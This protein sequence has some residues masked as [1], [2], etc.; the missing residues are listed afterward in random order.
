MLDTILKLVKKMKKSNTYYIYIINKL[1]DLLPLFSI[2]I[3][4]LM[5]LFLIFT[6]KIQY[7]PIAL[8]LLLSSIVYINL[9]NFKV[10][11]NSS[12]LENTKIS[13][14][15]FIT[16][17]AILYIISII[18]L[19]VLE[20]R[21]FLFFFT[22]SVAGAIIFI[23][24]LIS[25]LNLFRTT[26]IY[27][28]II[29]FALLI[30]WSLPYL[31]SYPLGID[32][33][34]FN[35]I[36]QNVI[37]SGYLNDLLI[38]TM[39]YHQPL[40]IVISSIYS[41]ILNV[42]SQFGYLFSVSLVEVLSLVFVALICNLFLQKKI[43]IISY[44]F[45]VSFS[46][47]IMWGW[48]TIAMT[49]GGS[50]FIIFIYT[51]LRSLSSDKFILILILIY[52]SLILTHALSSI[53]ALT[54]GTILLL[55]IFIFVKYLV[56]DENPCISPKK[57]ISISI[58]LGIISLFFWIYYSGMFTFYT[59][60]IFGKQVSSVLSRDT[61]DMGKIILRNPIYDGINKFGNIIAFFLTIMGFFKAINYTNSKLKGRFKGI[62]LAFIF[63]SICIISIT[64]LFPLLNISII[65]PTRWLYFSQIL[66]S[67]FAASG[68]MFILLR[69]NGIR[70]VILFAFIIFFSFT[71]FN[72]INSDASFD[73]PI[74]ED[75]TYFYGIKKYDGLS[76]Q[77]IASMTIDNLYAERYYS[78]TFTKQYPYKISDL[79][80]YNHSDIPE[81]S[82]V[83][84]RNN[85][86][87]YYKNNEEKYICNVGSNEHNFNKIYSTKYVMG[88][89][90]PQ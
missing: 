66:M 59:N 5:I 62:G 86:I 79:S 48:W 24:I 21:G 49:L 13:D 74:A 77:K 54:F 81:N 83:I 27:L 68:T 64:Y 78:Q 30:R 28:M 90:Y 39:Y 56:P 7:V 40:V 46:V 43:G 11:N 63:T 47:T 72:I 76:G 22:L 88:F 45:C 69:I 58:L 34:W 23:Y 51:L 14:K 33:W 84:A 70:K 29:I 31:Y 10:V 82:V 80:K 17:F 36:S 89:Y 57:I 42:N 19:F 85:S 53:I 20:C 50:L 8:S 55:S 12:L 61:I 1:I 52:I 87:N 16:S 4:F 9:S 71:F 67:I 32:P 2:F 60:N 38:G 37:N 6:K 75:I 73:S 18:Q 25:K 65:M 41:I 3:S 15:I 44:L 26:T 35:E